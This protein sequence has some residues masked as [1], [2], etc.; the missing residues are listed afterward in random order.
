MYFIYFAQDSVTTMQF[1]EKIIL[2]VTV[3]MGGWVI[4]SFVPVMFDLGNPEFWTV[5]LMWSLLASVLV[6]PALVILHHVGTRRAESARYPDA[7]RSE[8]PSSDG[9]EVP[10]FIDD[11]DRDDVLRPSRQSRSSHRRS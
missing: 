2:A 11:E 6:M 8:K 3:L 7:E 4:V 10:P 1:V 9:D 5:S